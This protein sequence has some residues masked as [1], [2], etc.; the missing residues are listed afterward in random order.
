MKE[1]N[2]IDQIIFDKIFN[3]YRKLKKKIQIDSR[4]FNLTMIQLHSLIFFKNNPK[5]QLTDLAEAFAIS[6]PTATSLTNKLVEMNLLKRLPDKND[7]RVIHFVLTKKGIE[8]LKK[9]EKSRKKTIC[10][11]LDKLTKE[12]KLQLL[13]ILN[14]LFS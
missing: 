4:I 9:A 7:R 2:K 6:L 14:K 1:K 12:E 13:K 3:L 5:C 10:F 8:H 11:L